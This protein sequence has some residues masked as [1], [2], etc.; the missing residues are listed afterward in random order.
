VIGLFFGVNGKKLQRQYKKH[1]SSFR[2]WEPKE[3]AHQWIIYP[4]NIGTHLA[5]DEVTLS[6][7]ELYTVVTNKKA[8]GK[9]GSLVAIVAGSK[10]EQV[11]EHVSK[12]TLKKN[13]PL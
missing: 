2:A 3:H 9:K 7:G 13:K 12:I 6:L 1:L 4:Q 11:I 8:K 10:T 5:I